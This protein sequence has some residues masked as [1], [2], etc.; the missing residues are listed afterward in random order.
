MKISLNW[1]KDYIEVDKSVEQ[2]A[3]LLSDL[4]FPCEGIE[5]F[6]DDTVIDVEITSNRGDCLSYIGIARELSVVTGKELKMPSIELDES[7]KTASD[8]ASVEIEEPDLCCRYTAR[9]IEGVKVGP[10]PDWLIKRLESVGMRSVNNVVDATNYA[11]LETG[12]PP[13][14][15]DY[16]KITEGKIIVRKARA[17]ERIVSIDASKCDLNPDMLIIADPKGPVAVAGV[18]GGLETEVSDATS[19]IL[20]EDAYFDPVSV[21]TTSR[22]LALPSEAAFRFERNV[23]TE[24]IDW[25]SKRTAQLIVQFA[26]GRVAKGIVD[27]W[28]K[29]TEQKQVSMRLSRLNKLMGIEVPSDETIRILQ[30]LCFEPQCQ[31]DNVICTPPSWRSDIYREVDIIEEVARVYGFDKIPT[32]KRIKIEVVPVDAREKMAKKIG[33][34]LNGCGYYEAI[35]VTFDDKSIAELLSQKSIDEH[36]AVQDVSRKSANL[37][38]QSLIGSL[39][40]VLKTNINAKNLPCRIYELADTFAAAE[41]SQATMPDETARLTLVCDCDLR[42]LTGVIVGLIES[43]DR[44]ANIDVQPAQLPWTKTGAQIIVNDVILGTIG[45]VSERIREK[46]D[47][48][49]FAP[50]AA[51]LDFD[52]LMNMQTAAVTVTP[53]PRFPAIERDLSIVVDEN[54]AWAQITTAV[55]A[56]AAEQLEEVQFVD[57][58]RGKG[59]DS[60]K[61]SVTLSLRFRDPDGT[62]THDAVDKFEADILASLSEKVRAQ[63]RTI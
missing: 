31:D 58:Y 17:G 15:F 12:Q 42:D 62:L 8:F 26:G 6:E 59:V 52:K 3:E 35:T 38:R 39:M 7:E 54:T 51:E 30:A 47:F 1:L 2:I 34:Y 37:L 44:Q 28:P 27:A 11:M 9:I 10:S 25:A 14:A 40:G 50:V 4:G 18:M 57:I 22:R 56:K 48:K 63:T 33:T 16:D 36:L 13:H 45:I 49:E 24:K 19:T 60:G 43:I 23:D 32:E 20:L 21:R 41:D 53:I 46:F 5:T 55:K 29:K 61:K